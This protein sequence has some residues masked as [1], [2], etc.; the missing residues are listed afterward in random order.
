MK[1]TKE[2]RKANEGEQENNTQTAEKQPNPEIP[3]SGS[4]NAVKKIQ[5]RILR[6][7]EKCPEQIAAKVTVEEVQSFGTARNKEFCWDLLGHF[8]DSEW[9]IQQGMRQRVPWL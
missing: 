6:D 3:S 5:A 4:R 1:A 7:W 9:Q 2:T 8:I